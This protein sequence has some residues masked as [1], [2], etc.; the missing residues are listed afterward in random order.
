MKVTITHLKAPWPVGAGVGDVVELE[1]A[2]IPEWA[3][4]KCKRA[5]DDAEVT[6]AAPRS[7]TAEDAEAQAEADAKAA[8][9][10][11]IAATLEAERVA[12]EAQAAAEAKAALLI[13]AKALGI[14]VQG[15]WSDERLAAE[16]LK[17][18]A[19]KA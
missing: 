4:G 6:A 14:T 2:D 9:D 3:V 1:A 5:D 10:A 15:K 12:G 17:A 7:L 18:K 13:E 19:A 11:Q 8:E 16:V